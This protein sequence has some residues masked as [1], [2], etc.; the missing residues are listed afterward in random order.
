MTKLRPNEEEAIGKRAA[1]KLPK[2]TKRTGRRGIGPVDTSEAAKAADEGQEPRPL[3]PGSPA[4]VEA[5]PLELTAENAPEDEEEDAVE[6]SKVEPELGVL[7]NF[8]RAVLIR[9]KKSDTRNIALHF[10]AVLS[11]EG[12][13]QFSDAIANRYKMMRNDEGLHDLNITDIPLQT[14]DVAGALDNKRV[15]HEVVAP[16]KVTL[17]LVQQSGTGQN[18]TG[19]RLTLVIPVKQLA[20]TL[21]WAAQTHGLLCWLKLGDVQRKLK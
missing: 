16:S 13:H 11:V 14:L 5:A 19:I 18:D 21:A 17:A 9:D 7:C 1:S 3:R 12:A 10:S 4:A 15:L 8:V 2:Q 6:V 20:D